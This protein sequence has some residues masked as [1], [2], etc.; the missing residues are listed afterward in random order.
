MQNNDADQIKRTLYL[1]ACQVTVTVGDS[2]LSCCTCVTSFVALINSL[3]CSFCASGA[4]GLVLFQICSYLILEKLAGSKNVSL[5][6]T[7]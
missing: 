3:V 1:H 2:G 4:L 7:V 5:F 6:C